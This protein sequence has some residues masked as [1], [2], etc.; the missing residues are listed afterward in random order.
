[1]WNV[2]GNSLQMCEGDYGITL[3]VTITGAT[4]GEG[5]ALRFTFK[6]VPNGETILTKEYTPENNALVLSFTSAETAKFPQGGYCYSL[7]WYKNGN[8]MCNLVPAASFKVVD[9]A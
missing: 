5:D 7:D 6:A 9:K 8:F 1:M 2:N 4:F 3:P